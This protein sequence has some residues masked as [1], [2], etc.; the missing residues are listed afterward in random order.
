VTLPAAAVLAALFA[1]SGLRFAGLPAHKALIVGPAEADAGGR[2]TGSY[3][4]VRNALTI[5][6]AAV[7]GYL[8][9]VASPELAFGVATAI[10]LVGTGYFLVF[11][12]EFEAYA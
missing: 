1:F 5:P 7:G 3:Y 4:L 9:Q 2:V 11:G 10:G 8:Y 6:S 12:E